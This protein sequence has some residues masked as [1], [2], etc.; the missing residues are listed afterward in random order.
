MYMDLFRILDE[1]KG[2][3]IA[4]VVLETSVKLPKKLGLGNVTKRFS[5]NVQLNYTYQNAV[6]N[7]LDKQ[8]DDPNFVSM[9][10]RWGEWE[11]FNKVISH[12]GERYMRY[13]LMKQT[14]KPKVEYFVDGRTAS[15][16]EID[17]IKNATK[18]KPSKRQA[19]VGLTE[20]QVMPKAVSFA[21][22]V[23]MRCD[24]KTYTKYQL[25]MVG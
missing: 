4:Y 13:Y 16:N 20:N 5:G 19:Q 24:G 21:N 3:K 14:T 7:R 23:E 6:N 18:P 12:K 1:I 15:Q 11:I 9:P 17:I 8:G 22:V 25:G 2:C 10:L